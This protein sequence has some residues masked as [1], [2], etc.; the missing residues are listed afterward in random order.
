MRGGVGWAWRTGDGGAV[1]G[2]LVTQVGQGMPGGGAAGGR[3]MPAARIL[4]VRLVAWLMVLR[5]AP[6]RVAMRRAGI[7][8][9]VTSAGFVAPENPHPRP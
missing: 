7:G 2:G 5:S 3:G 9:T 1:A 8:S 6:S 4:L